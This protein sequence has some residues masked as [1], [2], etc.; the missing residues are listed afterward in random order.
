MIIRTI[1]NQGFYK[2]LLF[3]FL[4]L[5][6][7]LKAQTSDNTKLKLTISNI[8]SVEG[9]IMVAVYNSSQKFLGDEMVVGKIEKVNKTGEMIIQFDDL[10]FGEYAISVY[11]DKNANQNLDTN[12][13]KI[14]SEPYGF[15][16]DARG[17]FGP[18]DFDAAKINFNADNRQHSIRLK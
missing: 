1:Q 7:T 3:L 4:I 18:P 2:F 13:F 5:S 17:S 10:P 14:P 16:N 12:L 6:G 15:S 9:N 11:H 8:K